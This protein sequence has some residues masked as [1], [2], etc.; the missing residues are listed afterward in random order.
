MKK[1]QTRKS[2]PRNIKFRFR[3][4]KKTKGHRFWFQIVSS[5][6]NIMAS[7]EMYL[8]WQG[9][10]K[11]VKAIVKAIQE[12]RYVIEEEFIET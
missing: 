3:E 8:Q 10:V 1:K 7:S 2:V 5:N 11:T 9:P 4:S 6:S 12:G